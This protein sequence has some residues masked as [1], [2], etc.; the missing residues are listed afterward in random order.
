MN[1][2]TRRAPNRPWLKN[3]WVQVALAVAVLG[4]VVA[5]LYTA[6]QGGQA[7]VGAFIIPTPTVTPTP[8]P[9]PI[10]VVERIQGL[11]RLETVKYTVE[12]VVE[13][14]QE[15][16]RILFF[17]WGS[18]R[19]LVVAYGEVVAGVDLARV[20]PEDVRVAGSKITLVLPPAEILSSKVN[21][22]RIRIYKVE[23]DFISQLLGEN[24][25]NKELILEL[26]TQAEGEIVTGAMADGILQQAETSAQVML[27]QFLR[28]LG[29]TDVEIIFAPAA[30]PAP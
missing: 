30:T 8:T 1:E 4:I 3:V 5:C 2:E 9:W 12:H 18:Y 22:D 17:E 11:G 6:W 16:Q 24:E 19:L 29:F 20:R 10:L 21:Q 28:A 23:Q 7:L 15:G 25:V 14:K 26:L 27:A 13:K